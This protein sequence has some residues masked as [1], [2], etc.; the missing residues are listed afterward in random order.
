MPQYRRISLGHDEICDLL[1]AHNGNSIT[2]DGVGN[3][4]TDGTWT[5]TWEHGRE[6]AKMTTGG[7]DD[8]ETIITYSYD[9]DGMRTSKTVTVNVYAHTHSY[10][11]KSVPATCTVNGYILYTCV[12]GDSY[13]TVTTL[14][15]GHSFVQSGANKVCSHCGYTEPIITTPLLP[16]DLPPVV[17]DENVG[18]SEAAETQSLEVVQRELVST[19]ETVYSYVYD[20][21][22]LRQMT[23]TITEYSNS[24]ITTRSA[25]LEFTYDASGTP[26]T[27]T[28]GNTTY[29]YV[30]NLQGDVLAI[31]DSTGNPVVEYVYDAWGKL[32]ATNSSMEGHVVEYNPLRYRGYVYDTETELYYLQSRYY[33]PAIGRFIN[34]DVLVS[35]GQGLLGNNMFAYCHNNPV[36][37]KDA[38]GTTDVSNMANEEDGNPFNDYGGPQAGGGG[39]S[40]R[41]AATSTG[42]GANGRQITLYRACSPAEHSN[43]VE[44]QQFSAGKNS[45]ESA[46]YF[47]TSYADA[48]KWG[49]AMYPDGNYRVIQATMDSRILD[50]PGIIGYLRLDGI[51]SAYLIPLQGLNT[52]VVCIY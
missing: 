45:Y 12:C 49:D 17:E 23:V 9:A 13:K 3:P 25:T 5:Y 10:T 15:K 32:L 51:G 40:S 46:K 14:A 34:A 43:T 2:Y 33:N 20:G 27:L 19:T 29:L 18:G 6:L 24:G 26:Q 21:G 35:T 39:S 4:L 38:S 52:Y 16:V 47:A 44:T 8:T 37:R 1:T 36:T 41:G 50:A 22:Q 28:C 48:T 7:K 42:S 11:S 31:L 30:T